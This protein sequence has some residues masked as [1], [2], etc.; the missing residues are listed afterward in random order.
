MKPPVSLRIAA[1][2][3]T[4]AAALLAAA[5]R[6]AGA[7]A[8]TFDT[9]DPAMAFD[10]PPYGVNGSA[11]FQAFRFVATV[12]GTL[13]QITVALGRTDPMQANTVFQLY[14]DAGGVAL[15]P[16]LETFVVAN[17]AAPDPTAPFDG[18]LVAFA[19]ALGPLLSAGQAYWLSFTEPEAANVA[20]SL[21]FRN[22]LGLTGTRLT[23]ELPAATN[24]LPAFR[25]EVVA[26]RVPAPA[27]WLLLVAGTVLLRRRPARHSS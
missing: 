9:F 15:G 16:L 14:D 2:A 11:Q 8:I 6:P 21:W 18:A 13:E 4:L 3:L 22:P 1:V 24:F 17:T 26:A 25:V 19:S 27:T 7:A 12:T 23:S 5:P 10:N 20:S